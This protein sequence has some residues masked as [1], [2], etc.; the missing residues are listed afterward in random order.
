VEVEARSVTRRSRRLAVSLAVTLVCFG[1]FAYV[2][3]A[4]ID[5]SLSG[6]QSLDPHR[7]GYAVAG[8]VAAA[9]CINALWRLREV[10]RGRTGWGIAGA[11]VW[12]A[13][14]ALIVLLLVAIRSQLG[15]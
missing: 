2:S 3:A 1:V 7:R 13:I 10:A 12:F 11:S 9:L 5:F 14:L 6:S 15:G 4:L 8:A